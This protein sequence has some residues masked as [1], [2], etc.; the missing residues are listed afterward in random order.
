MDFNKLMQKMRDLDQPVGEAAV[1]EC[2]EPMMGMPGMMGDMGKPDTPPPSM[3]VNINAQGLDNIEELMKLVAKVN[4]DSAPKDSPIASMG[5]D[6]GP[7]M[8][9]IKSSPMQTLPGMDDDSEQ[10]EFGSDDEGEEDQEEAW[11]NSPVGTSGEPEYHGLD[12]AIPDGNDLNKKKMTFPK[13]A[14]GD[15]PMLTVKVETK[16]ELRASIREELQR[17]LDEGKDEG[18]PGKNFAKIAK[19]AGGE[20]GN[21]I[22]GAVRAKLAKAGKL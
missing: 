8:L 14:G 11:G 22:A 9:S 7:D 13:V 1:A 10:D 15:N 21:K 17:R 19:K 12:A 20:K 6:D 18:K 3:S 5:M 16:E 4:P 2:G